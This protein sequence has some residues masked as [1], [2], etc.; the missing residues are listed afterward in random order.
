MKYRSSFEVIA[1]IL[2]ATREDGAGQ[3]AIIR[4][5][6]ITHS[7][8]KKY[9]SS[10]IGIGFIEAVTEKGQAA[11]KASEKGLDFLNQYRVLLEMLSGSLAGESLAAIAYELRQAQSAPSSTT[12][13]MR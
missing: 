8:F 12:Q 4:R 9:L 10:L 5:S 2:E 6:G 1:S 3:Y 11:Y 13:W 7:Q